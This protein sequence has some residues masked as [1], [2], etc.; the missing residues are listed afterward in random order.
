[1]VSSRQVAWY[2]A[3]PKETGEL[4]AFLRIRE[5][6]C[7]SFSSRLINRA[8]GN[9][10]VFVNRTENE[11]HR[12][13]EALLL[14]GQGLIL[15]VIVPSRFS[16]EDYRNQLFPLILAHAKSVHSIMGLAD[17]VQAIES[18]LPTQISERI[19]YHLMTRE[20]FNIEKPQV[21]PGSLRLR[22]ASAVDVR[23]LFPLQRDY[24]KEEVLLEPDRFNPTASFLSLQRS[25]RNEII[26]VAEI[27]GVPVAKA[28]TNARGMNYFQIGGVF[29]VPEL[30]GRGLG[31][32][33]MQALMWE[34]AQK[35]KHLCLFVKKS[36]TA[37]I[38]L[39]TNLGFT[40]RDRYAIS[41]YLSEG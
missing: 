10:R 8:G 36:N 11:D 5:W 41:Y 32:I 31:R 23:A 6:S 38:T 29:T 19:E 14:T 35:N 21:R 26:Y 15:P 1:M 16:V 34:I 3:A 12:I 7:V 13:V 28:G 18:L 39:Y 9:N 20:Y 4:L 30:R 25:L 2:P 22:R 17:Q 24:E 40:L 37:A 27:D 33:L